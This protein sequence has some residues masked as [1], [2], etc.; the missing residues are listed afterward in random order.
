MGILP[1]LKGGPSRLD[2]G[3]AAGITIPNLSNIDEKTARKDL[4]RG[5]VINATGGQSEFPQYAAYLPGY[6]SEWKREV[7]SR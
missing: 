6:G 1:K 2:D 3:K 5:Y 7:K 4:I